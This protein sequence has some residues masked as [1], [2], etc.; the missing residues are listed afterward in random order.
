MKKRILAMVLSM[1]MVFTMLPATS[2]KAEDGVSPAS[3]ERIVSPEDAPMDNL[4]RSATAWAAHTNQYGAPETNMNDGTL[5]NE[6]GSTSWNCYGAPADKFPM[7]VKLTWTEAQTMSSMR[8]M[9]WADG[10]GVPWLSGAKV[11]YLENGEFKDISSVGIEHAGENGGV[12]G[13]NTVWNIVNFANPI[14]TT[15][16]RMLLRSENNAGMGISEWEVFADKLKENIKEAKVTGP[17][18]LA[19]GQTKEYVGSVMP[20]T[21]E[22]AASYEWSV[23]SDSE[24][25]IEIQGA[26]NAKNVSVK[27]LAEG[28][29]KLHLKATE[30]GIVK[31]TDYVINTMSEQDVLDF[32]IELLNTPEKVDGEFTLP[33][34]SKNG[35]AITWQ[36]DNEA[37][38]INEGVALVTKDVERLKVKL[39]ATITGK[40][41]LDS[42]AKRTSTKDF[43]VVVYEKDYLATAATATASYIGGWNGVPDLA[44]DK[45][46]TTGWNGCR[47]GI[48]AAQAAPLGETDWIQYSFTDKLELTGSTIRYKDDRGGV[49]VPECVEFQYY[50]DN[51]S[52][53]K[54]VTP[55]DGW[56]YVAEKDNEY[57]FNAKIITNQ[58]KLI[59]TN[60]KNAQDA[61]A[62]AYI[63]EWG[64]LGVKYVK[65]DLTSLNNLILQAEEMDTTG[66]EADKVAALAAAVTAAKAVVADKNPTKAQVDKAYTDLRAAIVAL[67]GTVQTDKEAL[68]TAISAAEALT[69]SNYTPASWKKVSDALTAAKVLQDS[70]TAD[71]IEIDNAAAALNKA[72]SELVTKAN[73]EELQ[74]AITKAE[75]QEGTGQVEIVIRKENGVVEIE[76]ENTIKESVLGTN[77]EMKSTKPGKERHGFG[78]ESIRKII[79]LYHGEYTCWEELEDH[80]LWFTQSIR[81]R[82]PKNLEGQLPK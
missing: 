53:W 26:A 81:L 46:D 5:A 56:T 45:D 30:S 19:I 22:N 80:V 76:T 55:D 72:I 12:N 13:K 57:N 37:I 11:Q 9:W 34:V 16:L 69:S 61:T 77:S 32:D 4:A 27:A 73:K 48:A 44:K 75:G 6:Y 41:V 62:A 3:M 59:I 49:V 23:A 2:A 51:A 70:E 24:S 78:M 40:D 17:T 65:P 79:R 14:T 25:L 39:T 38:A 63:Y 60:G 47:D 64:L 71:Q 35:Y 58:I 7:E 36:S 29:A 21:L 54:T 52:A 31:E 67:G 50:D 74:A 68:N 1:A 33:T 42:D 82:I 18:E 20:E 8:V 15:E 28:K 66:Q 10:G 43:T